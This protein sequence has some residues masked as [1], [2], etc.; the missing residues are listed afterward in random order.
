MK[1]NPYLK[2]FLTLFAILPLMG[3]SSSESKTVTMP[4]VYKYPSNIGDPQYYFIIIHLASLSKLSLKEEQQVYYDG[5]KYYICP[6][7]S[8]LFSI[9]SPK[10]NKEITQRSVIL[11]EQ[12]VKKLLRES[13][14]SH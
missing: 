9:R 12:E 11:S 1:I 7:K 8:T 3:C 4:L 14:R 13:A 10:T 5:G 6:Q 2:E